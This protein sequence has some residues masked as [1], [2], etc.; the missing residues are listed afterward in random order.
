[1]RKLVTI[2]ILF[3]NMSTLRLASAFFLAASLLFSSPSRL[4]AQWTPQ[5]VGILPA[6]YEIWGLSVVNEQVVWGIAYNVV[7][8]KQTIPLTHTG[9]VVR[10]TDGGQT[11]AI[12][13]VEE[14]I[15]R[16]SWDIQA[17]D[18]LT[19]WIV[20]QDYNNG[21]G[22][23]LFKTTDGGITWT[24]KF[25]G[26]EGGVWLRFF[27]PQS[28]IAINRQSIATT[29]DG[30]ET[31][32]KSTLVGFEANEFT[33]FVSGTN[34]CVVKDNHL[35]F[36]T[37]MGRVCRS[38][39]RGKTWQF[40]NTG[41]GTTAVIQSVAFRDTLNGMAVAERSGAHFRLVTKDGGQ[42]WTTLSG[43]LNATNIH[44]L[45]Y[46][47]GTA[48]TYIGGSAYA[49]VVSARTSA[50]T[51]DSGETWKKINSGINFAA[52][53]FL[54]EK[55]GWATQSLGINGNRAALYKWNGNALVSTIEL[56]GGS[57]RVEAFPNPV[58]D[59][60]TLRWE[61]ALLPENAT[62][63]LFDIQGQTV[64]FRR[65]DGQPLALQNLPSGLYLLQIEAKGQRGTAKI[66]KQ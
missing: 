12:H 26:I 49:G 20:A 10:T 30:G 1:M 65:F 27:D 60:L 5:G 42:T 43:N 3:K 36:G 7:A 63:T 47:P 53:T 51:T 59:W 35:W 34:S 56:S 40:F 19:A 54:N 44:N 25:S 9:R 18:S 22:R 24:Q 15:G 45:A 52:F 13:E 46:V 37:S 32:T 8:A 50:Y 17:F 2:I 62:V 6:D 23:G 31:W 57:I 4:F 55:T 39:N 48:G 14:A 61:G 41:L 16:V 33:L 29:I 64:L 66:I 21:K 38:K 58:S 11:W 28:G